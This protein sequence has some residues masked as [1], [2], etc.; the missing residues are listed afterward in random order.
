MVPNEFV[1][2]SCYRRVRQRFECLGTCEKSDGTMLLLKCRGC[3][4]MLEYDWLIKPS[5]KTWTGDFA[6][7]LKHRLCTNKMHKD[8]KQLNEQLVVEQ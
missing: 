8:C 5:E 2:G 3:G 6:M 4:S 1:S 7:R